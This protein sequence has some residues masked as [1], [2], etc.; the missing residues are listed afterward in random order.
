VVRGYRDYRIALPLVLRRF[1]SGHRV[2][3]PLVRKDPPPTTSPTPSPT[4]TPQPGNL[5]KNGGFE[6]GW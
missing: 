4:P 6:L 1:F 3:L 5:L 2:M